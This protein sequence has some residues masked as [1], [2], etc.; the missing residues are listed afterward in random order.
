MQTIWKLRCGAGTGRISR[1]VERSLSHPRM[2]A[3]QPSQAAFSHW[4]QAAPVGP[5]SLVRPYKPR[6]M[7]QRP[8]TG[9]RPDTA[10]HRELDTDMNALC[11]PSRS[12]GSFTHGFSAGQSGGI[13]PCAQIGVGLPRQATIM[14]VDPTSPRRVRGISAS[15]R[16]SRSGDSFGNPARRCDLRWASGS[17]S[18]RPALADAKQ[19][20]MHH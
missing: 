11:N 5:T 17:E 2:P 4:R 9:S 16:R 1:V 3:F 14:H 13:R 6:T 18:S 15:V 7:T 19:A 8:I 10:P 20:I 12:I